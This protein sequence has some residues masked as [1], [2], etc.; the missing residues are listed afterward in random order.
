[1][2]ISQ[3]QNIQKLLVYMP[4][5]LGDCVMAI[6]TLR[7]LRE[8][9]PKAQITLLIRANVKPLFLDLPWV[10]RIVTVRSKKG[11]KESDGRR[12]SLVKLARRLSVRKFDLVVLL[13]NSFKSA[14]VAKLSG[15][16]RVVGYERDGRGFM[17]TDRLIPRKNPDGFVPVPTLDY[18]LGIARYLGATKVDHDMVLF[19]REEDDKQIDSMLEK[20]GINLAAG[21]EFVLLNPGAQKLMKRWPAPQFSEIANKLYEQHGLKIAITGSPSEHGILESI[22]TGT[23]VPVVNFAKLG[24]NLRLL[25]SAVK[26]SRLMITN[27]TGPRHIAA[28]MGTPVVSLF[29]PTGPEWTK[30]YFED[31]IELSAPGICDACKSESWAKT[32]RCMHTITVDAVYDSATELLG[33]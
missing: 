10:D 30:I 19:T 23:N 25:K 4:T 31:E 14:L 26:F 28:A 21:D 7:S 29:G 20:N 11:V 33:F 6:P 12:G 3:D 32:G 18:Y 17:L 16:K 13:P 27:D 2:T 24:M 15:A 1:M 22:E 5:W 8:I 9:Y